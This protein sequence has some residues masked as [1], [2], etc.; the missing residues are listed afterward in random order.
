M[1][2]MSAVFSTTR[3]CSPTTPVSDGGDRIGRFFKQ[4]FFK[5]WILPGLGDHF[6][7]V[8]WADF[9]LV[10]IYQF[11]EC[12]WVHQPFLYQKRLQ[13]LDPSSGSEGTVEWWWVLIIRLKRRCLFYER[14]KIIST[15]HDCQTER[16]HWMIKFKHDQT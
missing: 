11:I 10:K 9:R 15:S 5:L 2:W 3:M 12:L 16:D 1:L 13:G 8:S 6:C 4:I 14:L 7:P